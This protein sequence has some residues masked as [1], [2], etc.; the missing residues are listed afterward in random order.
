MCVVLE[1]EPEKGESKQVKG[2]HMQYA[3]SLF[4]NQHVRMLYKL[5]VTI[6]LQTP[7]PPVLYV[8]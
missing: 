7:Y 6:I 2:H 5:G 4:T 1:R 3:N 8:L